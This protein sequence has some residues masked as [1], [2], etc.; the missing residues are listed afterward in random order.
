MFQSAT[1]KFMCLNDLWCS[2]HGASMMQAKQWK[3][4]CCLDPQNSL[5]FEIDMM[6]PKIAPPPYPMNLPISLLFVNE[7]LWWALHKVEH[8]CT[9]VQNKI[10]N[11]WEYNNCYT[12]SGLSYAVQKLQAVPGIWEVPGVSR[13]SP[14]HD[15][16]PTPAFAEKVC[17]APVQ[18]EMRKPS[19]T[20]M[21]PDLY[22]DL[23]QI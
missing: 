10:N 8:P 4:A 14:S 18:N 23:C 5:G 9:L 7:C 6:L 15:T 11:Q 21:V 19:S 16:S 2:N 20:C 13:F 3:C 12:I 17:A 22:D 1:L